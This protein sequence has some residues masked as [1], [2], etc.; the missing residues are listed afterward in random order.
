MNSDKHPEP[1]SK[2]KPTHPKKIEFF[3]DK[4]RFETD[5]PN[6]TPRTLL[7]DFAGEDPEQTTLVLKQGNEL[8]KYTNLDEPIVLKNGMHFVVFHNTPTPVS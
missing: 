2:E 6:Q 8:H 5:Q 3:I 7:R 1:D 4:Q